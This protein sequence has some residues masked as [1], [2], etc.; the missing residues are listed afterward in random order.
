MPGDPNRHFLFTQGANNTPLVNTVD[1]TQNTISLGE[2]VP[3]YNT[4]LHLPGTGT[5]RYMRAMAVLD[6]R[7]TIA[8]SMLYLKRHLGINTTQIVGGD[9]DIW[10]QTGDI[11]QSATVL[12]VFNGALFG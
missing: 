5:I 12:D 4:S 2:V 7:A 11:A 10:S 1:L 6:E 9:L 3:P 8:P